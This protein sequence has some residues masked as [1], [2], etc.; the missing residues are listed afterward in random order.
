MTVTFL[1]QPL[2]LRR[3]SPF[4]ERALLLLGRQQSRLEDHGSRERRQERQRHRHDVA[5]IPPE[6]ILRAIAANCGAKCQRGL[7]KAEP[8]PHGWRRR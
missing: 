8:C 7:G 2:F 5:S 3:L 4:V 6:T 1:P